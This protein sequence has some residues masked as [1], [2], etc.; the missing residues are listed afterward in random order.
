MELMI[1]DVTIQMKVCKICAVKVLAGLVP[2]FAIPPKNRNFFD[3]IFLK[4]NE[5]NLY[6]LFVW[7]VHSV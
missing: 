7:I 2:C 1:G 5:N 4:K 6:V 3:F